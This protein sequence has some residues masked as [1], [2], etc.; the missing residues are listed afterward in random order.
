MITQAHRLVFVVGCQRSGTTL[1]GQILGAHPSGLLIDE[2]D[3]IYRQMHAIFDA[4]YDR[5]MNELIDSLG[6]S[7]MTKYIAGQ[8]SDLEGEIVLVLQAPNLTFEHARIAKAFPDSRIVYLIR[9]VRGIVASMLNLPKIPFVRNQIRFAAKAGFIE[10]QFPDEWAMLMDED[11][12][13]PVKMALIAKIKMSLAGN[14][15]DAG[16]SVFQV[17]YEDLTT[18]PREYVTRMCQHIG[19]PFSENCLE[20]QQKIIGYGPG[21]TDRSRP[22]DSRSISKWRRHLTD[23]AESAIWDVVGEYYEHLGYTRDAK[24]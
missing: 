5:E 2:T 16:L 8:R 19:V 1:T 15:E 11:V 10:E 23:E 17:K 24:V 4:K 14:F 6:R 18:S 21:G 9:D 22:I 7:A 12:G 3:D 13:T 20:H